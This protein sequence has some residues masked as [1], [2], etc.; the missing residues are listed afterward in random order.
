[1]TEKAE[2][3]EVEE[4]VEPKQKVAYYEADYTQ[5]CVI[6]ETE[7]FPEIS[8]TYRPLNMVQTANLTDLVIKDASVVGAANAN[9]EMVGKHLV[10]WNLL[11]PGG[12]VVDFRKMQELHKIDPSIMDKVIRAIRGDSK[13]PTE[14]AKEVGEELKNL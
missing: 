7:D 5:E 3:V 13:G 6:P 14:D 12:A 11:K 10:Q 1:M 9:L 8:F 2:N 4:V